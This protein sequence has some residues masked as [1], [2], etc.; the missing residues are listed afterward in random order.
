MKQQYEIPKDVEVAVYS[1]LLYSKLDSFKG[2]QKIKNLSN[3]LFR[4][5]EP[6]IKEVYTKLNLSSQDDNFYIQLANY[7]EQ[8]I[9]EKLSKIVE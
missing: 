3:K 8:G 5:L 6:K 2:E 9:E 4:A 7:F 1:L